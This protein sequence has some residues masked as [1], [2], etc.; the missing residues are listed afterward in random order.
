VSLS[1][2]KRAGG[3]YVCAF[4]PRTF[5]CRGAFPERSLTP[6]LPLIITLMH[7][8]AS[9]LFTHG[10][11]SRGA[12]DLR[13]YCSD[14]GTCAAVRLCRCNAF[15]RRGNPTNFLENGLAIPVSSRCLSSVINDR[16]VS[17][18]TVMKDGCAVIILI[19]KLT[20]IL[21]SERS[22]EVSARGCL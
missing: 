17:I 16:A 5:R 6:T 10:R 9:L 7:N 4:V 12:H 15:F 20:L 21:R 11:R 13:S 22:R 18:C 19:A 2:E 3:R 14:G 1:R 8:A